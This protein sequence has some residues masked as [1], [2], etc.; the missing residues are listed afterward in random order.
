MTV[1]RCLKNVAQFKYLGIT[2]TNQNLIEE[3]I[4]RR[5]NKSSNACYDSVQKLLSFCFLSKN[6]KL[7]N[8]QNYNFACGSVWV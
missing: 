2:V 6:I 1:K 7:K 4:K 3:E 8:I 5:S